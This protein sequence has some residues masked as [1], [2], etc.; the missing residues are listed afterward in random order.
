[1]SGAPSL[2]DAREL[3]SR[4][5]GY[6]AFRGLQEDVIADALAGRDV[7]A[8]LP[9]GGGKSLCYQIPMLLREGCGLVVS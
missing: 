2:P 4:I 1:M 8:I 7:L 6:P 9:T 3:L 5:Y